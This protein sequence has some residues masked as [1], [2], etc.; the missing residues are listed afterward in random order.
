[1][2]HLKI[3]TRLTLGFAA[4]TLA[5]LVLSAFAAW[6]INQV[7]L[8]TE[9]I[10]VQTQ[11][12]DLAN[13]WQGD[14]RQ[15]SARSLAVA[16]SPGPALFEFFKA[17]MAATSVGTTAIQK[18]F[19]EL[20]QDE[21]SRQRAQAVGDVRKVWLAV[22]DEA[23]A[24]KTAGDEAGT[25]AVVRDKLVP[26]TADYTRVTQ[27]LVD[28]ELANVRDTRVAIEAM[29]SQLFVL[30]GVLLALC[31]GIAVFASWSISRGIAKGIDM[32]STAAQ[33]IGEGDLSQALP[34]GGQDEIGHLMQALAK[35]QTSLAGV[36]QHVRLNSD[37]VA[38]ASA[39]IAQ[40]NQDLSSRTES[41][42]SAL[43]QTAASM[44]ELSSTVKQNA[45]NARQANQLAMSASQVAEQGGS[46]V[47]EVV[48]T[49]RGINEAS[50]KISDIISVIDGI[51][52][53]TNIRGGQRGAV[54]GRAQC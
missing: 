13:K 46:V 7:S 37:S 22:R 34:Q 48:D 44:E 11:L 8:A 42:A 52:F 10:E 1:M 25:Q 45:D 4:I 50:R 41:Q 16:Y 12:L 6:R 54:P 19:L 20:A 28:G 33:R 23:N 53:Q 43:E 17:D 2:N 32:A 26:A 14:V 18:K 30:G 51:A 24:L 31:V 36:V 49:M 5:F 47:A 29:F 3:S 15:N 21:G 35:M 40:G 38:T 39:E 27:N 9:R